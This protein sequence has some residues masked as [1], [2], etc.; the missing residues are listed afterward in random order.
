MSLKDLMNVEVTS[1]SKI[2]E[3]L[4]KSPAV[5]S[6]INHEMIRNYGYR[7]VYDALIDIPGFSPIQDVNDKIIGVR[8]V[9]GSTNQ[10]FLLLINGHRIT[11]SLWNL[12][13]IDYNISLENVRQI[14][15]IRGPGSAIYGRAALTAVINIITFSGGEIDG[16]KLD[17]SLGN[18]GYRKAGFM[19]GTK[20]N[21]GNEVE[22]FGHFA[23]L[24]G[25]EID[26]SSDYDGAVNQI[27]GVEIIDRHNFPTGGFGSRWHNDKW[28]INL[29][30]QQR[31]YTQPRSAGGQLNWQDI[32]ANTYFSE[33][34]EKRLLGEEHNFLVFDLE[35]KFSGK[36]INHI[37]SA[38][39]TYSRLRVREI[40][41]PFR[42]IAFSP[43]AGRLDSLNYSLGEMFEFDLPS[44]R[45]GF[46]YFADYQFGD[47]A[48][49]IW[50]FEAY[51]TVPVS[52]KF[53]SNYIASV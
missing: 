1:V 33:S 38:G 39:Y 43:G 36:K 25:E 2:E 47:N 37:L 6:V 10:K 5:V 32:K 15:V 53:T 49:V 28:E 7:T 22:V 4:R 13:D 30:W 23:A 20:D 12:T 41:I 48:T 18:H 50:G 24:K 16:L 8:G 42:D 44:S 27:S 9:H 52:D 14:E 17:L 35:R 34:F 31:Q 11:E 40:N 21:S 46:D 29:H 51:E 3:N 19:Y 26:V 45:Y